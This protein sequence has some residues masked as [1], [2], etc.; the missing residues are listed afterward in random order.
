MFDRGVCIAKKA[1]NAVFS[2]LFRGCICIY[3]R[4]ALMVVPDVVLRDFT[5][6]VLFL[7][8]QEVHGVGLLEQGVALVESIIRLWE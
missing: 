5:L 1:R 4:A 3:V 2:G 6:V 8:G 7:L